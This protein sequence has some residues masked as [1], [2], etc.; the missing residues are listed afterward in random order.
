LADEVGNRQF[1]P[2]S[3][4]GVGQRERLLHDAR[5]DSLDDL[6]RHHHHPPGAHLTER[7]ITDLIAFLRT[8]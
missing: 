5:A 7:D 1:N 2:P 8:L 6:F 4:R 3:L